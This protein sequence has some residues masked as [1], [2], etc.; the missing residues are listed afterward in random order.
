MP[1]VFVGDEAFQ[2]TSNV[3][4][5]FSGLHN[6]RTKERIFNYR[7]S[8]AR[9]VSENAFGIMS[10]SFRIFRKPILLE[11]GTATKVTLAAIHLHNYLRKSGSRNI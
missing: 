7:S 11:P 9:R 4:K 8:R 2:L 6:K 3:M 5:P 1:Y 10:S